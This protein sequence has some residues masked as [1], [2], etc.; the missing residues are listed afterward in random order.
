M[1]SGTE[2]EKFNQKEFAKSSH[3]NST[4]L[5]SGDLAGQRDMISTETLM[6]ATV[7]E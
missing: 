2:E 6:R 3:G 7:C 1:W 5:G 4:G